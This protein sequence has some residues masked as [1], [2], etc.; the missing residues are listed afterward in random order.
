MTTATPTP[1]APAGPVTVGASTVLWPMLD[2]LRSCAATQLG[3]V[4]RPVCRFP[5]YAADHYFPADDCDCTCD[6]GGQGVGWAR[7]VT[8]TT[9]QQGGQRL[10]PGCAPPNPLAVTVELGVHRCAPTLDP[11]TKKPPPDRELDA[12]TDG[13]YADLEALWRTWW[14]CEWLTSNDVTWQITQ[15]ANLG[16][17]GGCGAALVHAQVLRDN[18]GPPRRPRG[19]RPEPVAT[20]ERSPA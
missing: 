4:G 10:P 2:A 16:P 3:L 19:P 5:L 11:T 12:W 13:M 18:P 1:A 15:L 17:A 9:Q 20:S 7:L 6:T 8:A 14:C